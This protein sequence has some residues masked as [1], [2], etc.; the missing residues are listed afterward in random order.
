MSF[1]D[2]EDF[3]GF[4]FNEFLSFKKLITY[5]IIK[6]VYLL[7]VFVIVLYSLFTIFR[8]PGNFIGFLINFAIGILMIIFGNI[9]WRIM[10]EIVLVVFN[11]LGE[12]KKLNN[13]K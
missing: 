4:N 2:K 3:E 11:I 5:V 10:C 6:I 8:A 7:G 12:L 9:L 1:I 13:S